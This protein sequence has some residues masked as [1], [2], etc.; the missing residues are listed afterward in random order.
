M[1]VQHRTDGAGQ[2]RAGQQAGAAEGCT[3]VR[4]GNRLLTQGSRQEQTKQAG[5]AGA[6]AAADYPSLGGFRFP[7]LIRYCGSPPAPLKFDRHWFENRSSLTGI[8]CHPFTQPIAWIEIEIDLPVN[9][10]IT[11]AHVRHGAGIAYHRW[12]TSPPDPQH[13][14]SACL[15]YGYRSHPHCYTASQSTLLPIL[16]GDISRHVIHALFPPRP[17]TP[18]GSLLRLLLLHGHAPLP[19]RLYRRR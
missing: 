6:G 1:Y 16:L 9:I 10:G 14:T 4:L 3:H 17:L 2:S 5:E 18:P 19:R 13:I 7:Y 8:V 12:H 15:R 11:Y